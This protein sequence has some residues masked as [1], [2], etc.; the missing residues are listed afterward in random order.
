MKRIISILL[1]LFLLLTG[2]TKE[3]I[4]ESSLPEQTT[5]SITTT[6][7]KEST[8]TT[9]LPS[10][11]N[12]TSVTESTATTLSSQTVI[13]TTTT[14]KTTK[15][16]T[17][18]TTK[19]NET[20]WYTPG[21]ITITKAEVNQILSQTYKKPKNIIY[22][23]GDGMGANDII[24]SERFSEQCFSFGLVL[25]QIPMHGLVETHSANNPVTDSAASGTALATGVKTN[26]G[27][28]GKTPDLVD[29][30]NLS[31]IAR[32]YNKKVGIVTND[33]IVGATPSAFTV[34]NENRENYAELTDSIIGFMPDVL[35]GTKPPVSFVDS[36]SKENAS[37]LAKIL[38][39]EFSEINAV[40][41]TDPDCKKPL[42]HFLKNVSFEKAE[43]SLAYC[44]EIA[45]N[46]LKNDNG[47]FLMVENA[48]TDKAGHN[49]NIKGKIDGVVTLDRAVAVVLKFMKEN[50][51]TVLIITSDHETGGV[52]LPAD[53]VTPSNELFT[54]VAHTDTKVRVFAVGFGAQYFNNRTMDNT[55]IA[56]FVIN[57]VKGKLN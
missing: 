49:N 34:H 3:P 41:S 53:G 46:R 13:T 2:C 37:K 21:E 15:S 45:L 6:T 51:D 16:S 26:N 36:L 20:P 31:E 30:Q 33:Y 44:T 55:A 52:K 10:E 25:N 35:I 23:I 28:V 48:V 57:A 56:K 40:L 50:P 24:L 17:T 7:E 29:I 22:M 14:K 19:I 9:L 54:T 1:A 11:Q 27:L 8:E 12:S 32:S 18:T 47:F 4:S 42:L 5:A 38:M 39:P 43:N